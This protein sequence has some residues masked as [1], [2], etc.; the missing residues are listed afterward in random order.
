MVAD[1][2]DVAGT[3]PGRLHVDRRGCDAVELGNG[4]V[5]DF[6]P[7]GI[8]KGIWIRADVPAGPLGI[9]CD[10]QRIHQVLG[11]LVG[12]AIKFS[13]VGGVVTV[14]LVSQGREVRFCV[15]N[16][17]SGIM[18]SANSGAREKEDRD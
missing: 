18:S 1:L 8:A 13:P 16:T 5:E 14:E 15:S 10:K 11:N 6:S 2:P 9:S 4:A 12:N 3:D 17:G 7:L